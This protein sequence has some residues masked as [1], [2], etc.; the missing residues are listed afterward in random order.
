MTTTSAGILSRIISNRFCMMALVSVSLLSARNASSADCEQVFANPIMAMMNIFTGPVALALAMVGFIICG[1]ALIFGGE[2]QQF[3]KQ[4][5]T[6]VLVGCV[7]VGAASVANVV[8]GLNI[9]GIDGRAGADL[10]DANALC[11]QAW[12][13]S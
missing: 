2:L 6:V 7:L 11:V 4:M 10:N 9:T 3:I 13:G 8:F 12:S 5:F 1:V